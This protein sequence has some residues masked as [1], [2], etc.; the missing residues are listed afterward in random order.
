MWVWETFWNDVMIHIDK[1]II[2]IPGPVIIRDGFNE[3]RQS[4]ID[5]YWDVKFAVECLLN[6]VWADMS[7]ENQNRDN[8]IISEGSKGSFLFMFDLRKDFRNRLGLLA[9]CW[10]Q[11]EH[12]T[13]LASFPSRFSLYSRTN[14]LFVCIFNNIQNDLFLF[15]L[16]DLA[17]AALY[18]GRDLNSHR[19]TSN[20]NN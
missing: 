10:Q 19:F 2:I 13:Q 20:I 16:L 17:L 14:L 7:A 12:V 6:I 5:I 18:T 11:D 4:T 9:V 1:N 8:T 15:R 3:H